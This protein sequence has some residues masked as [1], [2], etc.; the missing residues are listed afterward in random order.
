MRDFILILSVVTF[1]IG[2]YFFVS[3][4]AVFFR[5]NVKAFDYDDRTVGNKSKLK[6]K[7]IENE[8]LNKTN[9]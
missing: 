2:S 8:Q 5:K 3:K 6:N 7:K 1:M 4:A 9:K